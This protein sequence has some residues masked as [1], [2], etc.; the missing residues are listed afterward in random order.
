M[1]TETPFNCLK[2]KT[3]I[4]NYQ[5]IQN[6]C[7]DC[8]VLNKKDQILTEYFNDKYTIDQNEKI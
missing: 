7:I 6:F 5:E 2:C 3:Q 4:E 8:F 1:E